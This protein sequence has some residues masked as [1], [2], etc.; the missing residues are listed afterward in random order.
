ML[1]LQGLGLALPRPWRQVTSAFGALTIAGM[2]I[3][4]VTIDT[5]AEGA[6]IGAGIIGLWLAVSLAILVPAFNRKEA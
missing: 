2:L 1:V 5:A 4:V 6:N 3:A